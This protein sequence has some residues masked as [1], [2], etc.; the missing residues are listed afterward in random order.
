M[1]PFSHR[2]PRPPLPSSMLVQTRQRNLTNTVKPELPLFKLPALTFQA[3]DAEHLCVL[4]RDRVPSMLFPSQPR[5]RHHRP[6]DS[7]ASAGP[8]CCIS[9]FRYE[10]NVHSFTGVLRAFS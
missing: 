5:T 1:P 9:P 8:L 3:G 6:G 4:C 2:K 10:T 7:T